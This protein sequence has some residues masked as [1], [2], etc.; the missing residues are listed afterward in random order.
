[1]KFAYSRADL[2]SEDLASGRVLFSRPGFTA[3]PVRL[4]SELFLRAASRLLRVG[5]PPPYHM[6]DPTCGGG[7]LATVLGFLHGDQLQNISMS[8]ISAEAVSVAVKNA[9]LLTS[10]DLSRRL[11]ELSNLVAQHDRQSHRA[12]LQGGNKLFALCRHLPTNVFQA[13]AAD[14]DLVASKLAALPPVDL[15]IADVPY[16]KQEHWRTGSHEPALL[17]S[18]ASINVPVVVLATAKRIKF[19]HPGFERA[20]KYHHGHRTLWLFRNSNFTAGASKS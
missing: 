20:G 16:G 15:V 11:S 1:M 3:F 17:T 2:P 8:D 9:T 5:R 10:E 14:A 19:D 4:A 7:Y 12:A 18:L 6:Y 13:D